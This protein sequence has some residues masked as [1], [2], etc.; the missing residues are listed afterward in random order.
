MEQF[1][2]TSMPTRYDRVFQLFQKRI[3]N[4]IPL[5][6]EIQLWGERV[7]R[8]GKGEPAVKILVKDH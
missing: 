2:G 8:L 3:E 7:Y 4:K 6:I 1:S 5:P